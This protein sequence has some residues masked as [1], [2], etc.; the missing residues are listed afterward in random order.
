VNALMKHLTASRLLLGFS[1]VLLGACSGGAPTT[2]NPNIQ[3]A[4]QTQTYNG[5][6]PDSADV[7]AFETNL[8]V[9]ISP[10]TRCGNCHK[11]NGQSPMFARSD[12]INQAYSAALT[13]VNLSQPETSTMVQKVGGGHNCWLAS[14]QA[15][16]DILT[17]WISNWASG[18]AGGTGGT[19]IPLTAPPDQT[20]GATKVFPADATLFSQTVY[21]VVQQWCSRC[22]SDT[23]PTPQSPF[24][25]SNTLATAY[26]AAQPEI[27]LNNP[28]S[29]VFYTR[30]SQDS[31]NC[32]GT[33]V[34]CTSSAATMLAAIQAFANGIQVTPLDPTL[35]VS[36]ELGMLQGTVASGANRY[37]VH[38]IAKWEFKEGTGTTAYDTS[39]VDPGMDLTLSGDAGWVGGWGISFTTNG[40]AQA[41]TATST[42]LYS[43]LGTSGQYSLEVWANAANVAQTKA[44]IISYSGGDTTRNFTL[45]QNAFQ[46]N[47]FARSSASDLNGSPSLLTN[48]NNMLAQAAL[49][50]I[51]MTYDPTNG[52]KL[53]V[54]GVFTGDVDSTTGGVLNNWDN[55]FA[56]LLGNETS[57]DHPWQ[58]Q[59]R[60]AA[61]HDAALTQQQI[62]ENFAA[63]VGASYYLLFNVSAL[64]NTPQAYIMFTVSQ[65]DSY[66]YL[67]ARPTFISLDPTWAPTSPIQIAGI[68][69]GVNGT[70]YPVDQAWIPLNVTVDSSDYNSTTGQLLS[71]LGAV[72]TLENGPANDMF[73]LTFAQIGTLTHTYTTPSPSPATPVDL[74][75]S[76]TLGARI[77]NA[78]NATMSKLSTVSANSSTVN[79]TYLQVETG[80]PTVY[81]IQSFSSGANIA[82][83]QLAMQYCQALVN[84]PVLGPA[85]FPGMNFNAA[86]GSAFANDPAMDL[87]VQPLYTN[88]VGQNIATQ[89][90]N[91]AV[92]T[93][94]YNLIT[95]LSNSPTPP[96]TTS[97]Q[98]TQQISMAA[99]T[100]LLASATTA[101]Y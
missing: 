17:T 94:L 65:Y 19:Q 36:E 75:A 41:S 2:A 58:G 21:P 35:I 79:P 3:A 57:G 38:D 13:V 100:A 69:V 48:A 6:A 62:Q 28:M 64:T 63:G 46:Y 82:A 25:A 49:Q 31:H 87:I 53:Y 72:F 55:S 54:N 80:L 91:A 68:R 26:A 27:S 81:N 66:S 20:V 16:A 52:R 95:T 39:G 44:N 70:E 59:I 10:V 73:F 50:H 29:S 56:F 47:M 43:K 61:V 85:F 74:P 37:D 23:A 96:N 15:C 40:R 1:A 89:P 33:P 4:A 60:F 18:G 12:D 93:E 67:F 84:D 77:F 90:T 98:R 99:C 24:F 7:Q 51:V 34:N 83:T 88:L 14:P 9:N 22:H 8:W 101:L 92:S 45:A 86:P 5:P 42:K 97:A 71:P 78:V 76:A 32:W 11:A 30:L